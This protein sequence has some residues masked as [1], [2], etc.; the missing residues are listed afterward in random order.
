MNPKQFATI[1]FTFVLMTLFAAACTPSNPSLTFIDAG[2]QC[3]DSVTKAI[4]YGEFTVDLVAEQ[5]PVD[6]PPAIG[7]ERSEPQW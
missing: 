2:D 3:T 4:P 6:H 1:G 5:P 7:L